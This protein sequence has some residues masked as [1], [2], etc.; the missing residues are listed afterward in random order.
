MTLLT[1]V[2]KAACLAT[3]F[4]NAT[5]MGDFKENKSAPWDVTTKGTGFGA[6][7]PRTAIANP[8]G[9]NQWA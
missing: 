4:F 1:V 5:K 8:C 2:K 9:I 3:N 7:T 6:N